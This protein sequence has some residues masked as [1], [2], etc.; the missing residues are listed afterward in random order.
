MRREEGIFIGCVISFLSTN[1][2][3]QEL[4]WCLFLQTGAL[5]LNMAKKVR[6]KNKRNALLNK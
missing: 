6:G 3:M 4:E 5:D 2:Y 1:I